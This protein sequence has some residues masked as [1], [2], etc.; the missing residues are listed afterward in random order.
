MSTQRILTYGVVAALLLILA[1]TWFS[2]A[3]TSPA[4]PDPSYAQT[5]LAARNEKDAWLRADSASPLL[6]PQRLNFVGL[7]YYPLDPAFRLEARFRPSARGEAFG[8][9][10]TTPVGELAFSFQGRSYTLTAYHEAGTPPG[11]LFIPFR[12]RTNGKTTYGGGRY[13]LAERTAS[14]TIELDF[15]RAYHPYCAYNPAYICPAVPP[16]NHLPFSVAAGE[17]GYA[18][19]ELP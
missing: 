10:L 5:L 2:Q 3:P 15:N 16:H 9:S 13:L 4:A 12:D 8:D 7:T 14:G 19:R 6:V 1:G 18:T 11:R 17:M